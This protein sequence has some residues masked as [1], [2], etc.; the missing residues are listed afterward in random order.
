MLAWIREKLHTWSDDYPWSADEIITW[1]MLYYANNQ[2]ATHIYKES[3]LKRAKMIGSYIDIPVGVSIFPKDL[4]KIP[5]SW[6]Q[7]YAH[8]VTWTIHD[9]GGHFAAHE[10]PE[11]LVQDVQNLVSQLKASKKWLQKAKF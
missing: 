9:R 1:T 6:G 7:K 2:A 3:R 11:V 10:T 5:K 8:I 4:Y